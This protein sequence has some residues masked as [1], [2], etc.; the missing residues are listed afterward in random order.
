MGPGPGRAPQLQNAAPEVWVEVSDA[1]ALECGWSEGDRL[2]ITTPRGEV[3]ARLRVSGVRRGVL[4]LPFHYGYWD[5]GA[6]G[7]EGAGRAANE[8]TLTDWDPVSKQPLF[9]AAAALAERLE[10]S[11]EDPGPTP[12]PGVSRGGRH[13]GSVTRSGAHV[14]EELE[15]AAPDEGAR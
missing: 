13:P 14:L 12:A 10:P 2:R 9:K 3:E 15:G 1:D 6:V 7:P 4:F 8:L 5:R 11:G